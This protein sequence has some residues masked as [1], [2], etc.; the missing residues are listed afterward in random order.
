MSLGGGHLWNQETGEPIDQIEIEKQFLSVL[1]IITGKRLV[2]PGEDYSSPNLS[3]E[4]DCVFSAN[5]T[6]LKSEEDPPQ[7]ILARRRCICGAIL[8]SYNKAPICS[9]CLEVFLDPHKDPQ[10][11]VLAF[12]ER[13]WSAIYQA[14]EEHI[15]AVLRKDVEYAELQDKIKRVTSMFSR[16]EFH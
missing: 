1:G 9:P 8:N 6:L 15:Q 16:Y 5:G 4:V 2:L 13:Y 12:M 11:V 7:V 14:R 3:R 10:P